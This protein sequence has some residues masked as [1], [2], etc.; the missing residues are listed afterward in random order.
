MK[1]IHF[2][3][4]AER[5]AYLKGDF[6]EI[7]P[8]E[9]KPESKKAENAKKEQIKAEDAKKSQK[10]ASKSKKKWLFGGVSG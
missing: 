3:S 1:V 10:K 4:Q 9:A 6:E 5:L 2:D 8:V 7:V